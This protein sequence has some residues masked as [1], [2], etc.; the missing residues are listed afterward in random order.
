MPF[1]TTLVDSRAT[2]SCSGSMGGMAVVDDSFTPAG[3]EV[4]SARSPGMR[5]LRRT[6]GVSGAI[7]VGVRPAD[8]ADKGVTSLVNRASGAWRAWGV[9]RLQAGLGMD[10][11]NGVPSSR[12][13]SAIGCDGCASGVRVW[14]AGVSAFDGMCLDSPGFQ[15]MDC[16]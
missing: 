14:G 1:G 7:G 11:C 15:R 10:V 9:G 4:G 5:G 2:S 13:L 6:G 16:V 12:R 8:D 3:G